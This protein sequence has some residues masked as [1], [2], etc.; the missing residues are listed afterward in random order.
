MHDQIIA[1]LIQM[2]WQWHDQGHMSLHWGWWIFLVALLLV[3]VWVALAG[4]SGSGESA[5]P[6]RE[7]SEEALRR[8]FAEGDIGEEEFQRRLDALRKS[9]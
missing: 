6:S 2:P 8:R 4:A 5:S 9:R 1:G 3:L 7:S